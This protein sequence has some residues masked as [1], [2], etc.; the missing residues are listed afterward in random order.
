ME[1]QVKWK[2][3]KP[4]PKEGEIRFARR[5][6]WL[7]T[8]CHDDHDEYTVWLETYEAME[9]YTRVYRGIETTFPTYKWI[10]KK[11]TPLFAWI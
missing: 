5:F 10:A 3:N 11:N 4:E 7:P 1:K 9:V 8:G 2:T 6:A